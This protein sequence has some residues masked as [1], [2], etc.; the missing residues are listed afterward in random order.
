MPLLFRYKGRN[1]KTKKKGAISMFTKKRILSI[2]LAALLLLTAVPTMLYASTPPPEAEAYQPPPTT[3]YINISS[4]SMGLTISSGIATCKST[5]IGFAGTTKI[6]ATYTL[7]IK[8][9]GGSYLDYYGW[10]PIT[11]ND[12]YLNFS[13][14]C[15]VY[16]GYT[17]RLKCFAAVSRN[18]IS[19]YV[20]LYSAEKSC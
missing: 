19:E 15:S 1:Q 20:E 18:G 3:R 16:S 11:V 13:G 9:A 12:S 10:S 7:Q 8:P 6:V 2:L 4:T 14:T 17:Y 5:I